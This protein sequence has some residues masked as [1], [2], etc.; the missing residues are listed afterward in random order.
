MI[1]AGDTSNKAKKQNMSIFFSDN[2]DAIRPAGGFKTILADAPWRFDNW[3]EA[4]ENRNANQHYETWPVELIKSLPVQRLAAKDCIMFFWGAWPTMPQWVPVIESW[5]FEYKALAWDWLKYNPETGKYAF[6]GGYTS[7]KNIEP[8]MICTRGNPRL[9]AEIPGDLFGPAMAGHPRN[10][11]DFIFWWPMDAI[12]APRREHS[13]KPDE[14][15]Q[16]IEALANGP[17]VELFG[18]NTRPGWTSWGNETDKFP[19]VIT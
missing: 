10:I 7:R 5:G 16:R 11:R 19:E 13:R 12:R 17:Y 15:Y 1:T 2:F 18:R 4:G 6:G 8:C 3:S 14:Q 9:K